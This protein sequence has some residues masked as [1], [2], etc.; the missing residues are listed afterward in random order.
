MAPATVSAATDE[1]ISGLDAT[2]AAGAGHGVPPQTGAPRAP[3]R[4]MLLDDD[5][6]MLE[7]LADTL[8]ELGQ[9]DIECRCDAKTAIETMQKERPQLLICDLSMPDMDG[10]EFL[11]VAA[12]TGYRGSI[13][14]LSGMDSG[15]RLAA[16]RLA[17]AQG[18]RVLGA[19]QKPIE[20][21]DLARVL[22]AA[23]SAARHNP[24]PAVPGPA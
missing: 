7:V 21:H 22:A 19:Y 1:S 6:L 12:D 24:I 3:L 13:V 5:P 10:I 2:P 14:L 23:R 20:R 17:V 8:R 15:V 18:L 4:I 9:T 16:E 11:R